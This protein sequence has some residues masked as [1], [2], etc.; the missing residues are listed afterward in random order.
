MTNVSP[1]ATSPTTLSG[2]IGTDGS[3]VVTLEIRYTGTDS[4]RHQL[5]LNTFATKNGNTFSLD[6]E[7]QL[8]DIR[9]YHYFVVNDPNYR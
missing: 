6:S 1:D 2:L 7:T 5:Y 4:N 8:F 3:T 9:G